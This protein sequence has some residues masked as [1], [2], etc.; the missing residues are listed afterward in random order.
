M[1]KYFSQKL[2]KDKFICLGVL[3]LSCAIASLNDSTCTSAIA[4]EPPA[5][6]NPTPTSKPLP[7]LSPVSTTPVVT[8]TNKVAMEVYLIVKRSQHRVYVY[9]GKQ[10]IASYPVAVGK[11]GWETPLGNFRVFNM[12]ENPIFK[13]FRTGK[14]IPPGSENPLGVRWIGFWTDGKTQRGFHGTDEDELIGQSV[15]HSC[16]RM[17]NKDVIALYNQVKIGTIVIVER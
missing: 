2:V 9:Q 6:L 4:Q 17:H 3:L 10:V 15:S 16:I 11:I 13:N 12:E 8:P 7:P 1:L 14:I 5:N